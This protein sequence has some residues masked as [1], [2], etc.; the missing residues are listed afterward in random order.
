MK[1]LVALM[2]LALAACAPIRTAAPYTAVLNGAAHPQPA[3]YT[4]SPPPGYMQY[5]GS[6]PRVTCYQLGPYLQCR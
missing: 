3:Y 2:L 5:Y 1:T 6:T 4:Q